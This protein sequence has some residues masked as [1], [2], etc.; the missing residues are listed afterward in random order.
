MPGT[1]ILTEQIGYVKDID[2][3]FDILCLINIEFLCDTQVERSVETVYATV[4][5]SYFTETFTDILFGALFHI[6]VIEYRLDTFTQILRSC[7]IV[8]IIDVNQVVGR[9]KVAI[10]IPVHSQ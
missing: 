10:H 5:L 6:R 4:A 3:Q 7:S 9:D 1:P 8:R 2:R